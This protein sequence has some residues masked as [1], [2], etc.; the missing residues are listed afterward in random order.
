MFIP[1]TITGL[2]NELCGFLPRKDVERLKSET[3]GLRQWHGR[4]F[5]NQYVKRRLQAILIR[6]KNKY[7]R[8]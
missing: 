5:E 4:F 6:Y 7:V 1:T 2:T 3:R 8:E